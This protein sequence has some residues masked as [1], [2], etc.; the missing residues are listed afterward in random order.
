MQRLMIADGSDVVRK[1]GKRILSGFDFLVTEASNSLEALVRCEAELP[2]LAQFF[3]NSLVTADWKYETLG[4]ETN[5][6]RRLQNLA[7]W[8]MQQ[9]EKPYR[10]A[11]ARSRRFDA[12][13]TIHEL[14][15]KVQEIA[16]LG[17]QAGEGWYLTADMM[18]MI[19]NGTPNIICAQPFACL[20]NHVVGKGMFRALRQKYP[21]AN[22]VAIDY[23]PG[24]SEVNQLNR[25]KLMISVAKENY[26]NNRGE[27][28]KLEGDP[29]GGDDFGLPLTPE[30]RERL[31]DIKVR[32][33]V[34]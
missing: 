22:V 27:G 4:S 16:Q 33:A 6:G 32:A 9:Y 19:E 13:P 20:P 26:R 7:L 31:A 12:G 10:K 1:V 3:H 23:D 21:E 29:E 25:I 5:K 28:F 2:S 17:N 34:D 11:L 8:V 15:G 18:D 24:A 30:Q 14:A